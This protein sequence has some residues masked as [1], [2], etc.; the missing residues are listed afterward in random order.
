[1]YFQNSFKY[2]GNR[3]FKFA[4]ALISSLFIY[5]F[6]IFFQPFGVNNYQSSEKITWELVLGLIWIIPVLFLTIGFNE[7]ILRPI[8]LLNQKN[9]YL[10]AWFIYCFIS[11]GSSS[12]LLYNYLGNF[13]DFSF[14]SYA[15]HILEV[16][17]VLIFPFFGTVF[18]YNYSMITKNYMETRS[19]SNSLS[20]LNEV[21]LIKGDY[22]TDQIA[23][24]QNAIICIESEDN[25]SGLT[26]LENNQVKKHLIRA[27][28]SKMKELIDN[29]LFVQCNRS[30]IS[31]LYHL[32]SIKKKP[33]GL[34]LKLRYIEEPIK[35][36]KSNTSK[37][38]QLA[39][40]HFNTTSS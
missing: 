38:L 1:M 9:T 3:K 21:I 37:V 35:V 33:P 19:I 23:L 16:S 8:I 6:L 30:I 26:F 20:A 31:N 40:K 2:P 28:L 27:T 10:I 39:E 7:F 14:S 4:L 12:F 18:F 15:K 34:I 22:K 25:Y 24:R 11:V 29:E 17:S 13:H 5:L 36:S 32:E